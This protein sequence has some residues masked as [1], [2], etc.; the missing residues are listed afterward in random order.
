MI[1]IDENLSDRLIPLLSDLFQSVSHVKQLGLVQKAD[2]VIWQYAA[3]HRY[4]AILT[5]DA[6][7]VSIATEIG[8]PP[9]VIRIAD[10]NF[11]TREA[12]QL[13]RREAVRIAE[14]LRSAKPILILRRS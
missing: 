10:C 6:E 3:I 9:K 1:L 11:S 2:R 8:S 12:A 4:D 14:F 5:A 7:M 13:I